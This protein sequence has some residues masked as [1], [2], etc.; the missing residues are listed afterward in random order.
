[1]EAFLV[2]RK[3]SMSGDGDHAGKMA[4]GVTEELG[5]YKARSQPIAFFWRFVR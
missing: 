5:A 1:L 4:Q 2:A 3:P